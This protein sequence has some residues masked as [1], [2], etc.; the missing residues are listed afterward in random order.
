MYK[1]IYCAVLYS[2]SILDPPPQVNRLRAEQL[3]KIAN[4]S[5]RIRYEKSPF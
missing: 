1:T 2:Y 5:V 3:Y 4:L